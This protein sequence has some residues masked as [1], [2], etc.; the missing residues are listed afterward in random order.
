MLWSEFVRSGAWS[1]P[2]PHVASALCR[3]VLLVGQEGGEPCRLGLTLLFH[4]CSPV[5]AAAVVPSTRSSC[6]GWSTSTSGA[7][8]TAVSSC[9]QPLDWCAVYVVGGALCC[10]SGFVFVH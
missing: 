10:C 2:P 4:L 1:G 6:T 9:E 3:F 8:K 7:R 5:L